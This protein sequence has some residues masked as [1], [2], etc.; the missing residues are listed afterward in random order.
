MGL[1]TQSWG[2]WA[3]DLAKGTALGGAFAAAGGARADR[4]D[5]PLRPPL[6]G[7]RARRVASGVALALVFLGPVA[8]DPLFNK[9]TPLP[10]GEARRDVLDL[11]A[12]GRASTWA[13]STRSTPRAA[14]PRPTP[15]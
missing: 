5:A 10:D 12:P 13:R 14:R 2:G 4:R 9:F 15:T 11:A 6:V 8:L 3:A 1:I 7:A